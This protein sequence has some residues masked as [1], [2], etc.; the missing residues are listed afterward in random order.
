MS[1]LKCTHR[2]DRNECRRAGGSG[3]LS[4]VDRR[5]AFDILSEGSKSEVHLGG[6]YLGNGKQLID[7]WWNRTEP[8]AGCMYYLQRTHKAMANDGFQALSYDDLVEVARGRVPLSRDIWRNK[9]AML[10]HIMSNADESILTDMREWKHRREAEQETR[11]THPRQDNHD[12]EASGRDLDR[13]LELATEDEVHG[14]YHEFYEATSNTPVCH[15]VCSVCERL[16]P[17]QENC[18]ELLALS[19]IAQR[20]RL[21]PLKSH[22]AHNLYDGCLLEPAGVRVMDD[23][24]VF[25]NICHTCRTDLQRLGRQGPPRLSLANNL[26]IGPISLEVLKLTVPEQ[27]ITIT[28]S[29]CKSRFTHRLSTGPDL[30]GVSASLCLQVVYKGRL[31]YRSGSVPTSNAWDGDQLRN[32]CAGHGGHGLWEPASAQASSPRIGDHC[33]VC[34]RRSIAEEMV[35]D[36]ISCSESRGGPGSGDHADESAPLPGSANRHGSHAGASGR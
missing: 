26:F 2:N 6:I 19:G 15:A 27:V 29:V 36:H 4:G 35:E 13:Y 20:T 10:H 14:C 32:E 17:E 24:G 34:Q 28:L 12:I 18:F 11:H 1:Q 21:R 22:P 16:L 30:L 3:L 33:D 31:P 9:Q 8:E 7:G 23:R 5:L 25:V